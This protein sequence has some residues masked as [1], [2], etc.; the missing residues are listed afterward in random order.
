[1]Y[2]DSLLWWL[3]GIAVILGVLG[4]VGFLALYV[5][6]RARRWQ[7]KR[8]REHGT[9]NDDDERGSWAA[10]MAVLVA[11]VSVAVVVAIVWPNW[12]T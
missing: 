5:D 6:S 3:G 2:P 10:L 1:M 8:G 4:L 11:F 7:E 9:F 12:W